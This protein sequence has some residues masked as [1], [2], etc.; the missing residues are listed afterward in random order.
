MRLLILGGTR[1]MGFALARL[2]VDTGHDVTVSSHRPEN[3][4][5]GVHTHG[6]ERGK[7]IASL[8]QERPF[9][10]VVDFTAYDADS[11]EQAIEAFSGA[12]YFLISSIWVA[13]LRR[14]MLADTPVPF[15]VSAPHYLP[16][17]TRKYIEGKAGAEFQARKAHSNGRLSVA[18]RLPI[19][20]GLNDH[21]GRLDYYRQRVTDGAEQIL[22]DG[23]SNY[24]QLGWSED[25]VGA[26]AR[27][28]TVE[29]HE[30]P[31]LLEGLQENRLTVLELNALIADAEGVKARPVAVS[32][33]I[34]AREFPAF[35]D[36]EPLWREEALSV[37]KANLF[38]V[39]GW[40]PHELRD[41]LVNL[42]RQV[43]LRL[44]DDG[45]RAEELA[46][47]RRYGHA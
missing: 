22:V 8:S 42:V 14:G 19:V 20:W 37:S 23:G 21:T 7:A 33:D 46:F 2:L 45:L 9:D 36:H 10:V 44:T 24:V 26:I 17:V 13:K 35:L 28:I 32:K 25:M 43:P 4:P 16:E 3:A 5:R 31:P 11:A 29:A 18:L 39:T 15:G 34:L 6:G 47:L 41:W 38:S 40:V 12:C 30:L 1:F 27:L